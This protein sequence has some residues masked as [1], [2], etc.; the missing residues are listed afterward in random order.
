MSRHL[1]QINWS[2]ESFAFFWTQTISKFWRQRN[3]ILLNFIVISRLWLTWHH[4]LLFLCSLLDD[5][6]HHLLFSSFFILFNDLFFKFSSF[7]LFFLLLIVFL[8]VKVK[9][10]WFEASVLNYV[11]FNNLIWPHSFFTYIVVSRELAAVFVIFKSWSCWILKLLHIT[12]IWT[13]KLVSRIKRRLAVFI[14]VLVQVNS[15]SLVP[16][17]HIR[18]HLRSVLKNSRSDMMRILDAILHIDLVLTF[19]PLLVPFRVWVKKTSVWI[20]MLVDSWEVFLR[21]M[22]LACTSLQKSNSWVLFIKIF[23]ILDSKELTILNIK[24]NRKLKSGYWWDRTIDLG[25]ISTMLYRLS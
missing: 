22:N 10:S 17:K 24:V 12:W 9:V 23:L 3:R 20:V 18:V 11:L 7:F 19:E 25:V 1:S 8:L 5:L 14:L 16:F 13:I 6:I 4:S 2:S 15:L 21:R